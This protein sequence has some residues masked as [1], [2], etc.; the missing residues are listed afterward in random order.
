MEKLCSYDGGYTRN[1]AR[2]A[3][4][5][6]D[7]PHKNCPYCSCSNNRKQKNSWT[8]DNST[9]WDAPVKKKDKPKK[10]FVKKNWDDDED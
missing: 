5:C 6:G 3:G 10:K 4:L 8:R 1:E 7:C 9:P 2:D